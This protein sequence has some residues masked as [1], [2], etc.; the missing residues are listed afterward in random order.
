[1]RLG[2]RALLAAAPFW[3]GLARAREAGE[4]GARVVSLDL[5]LTECLLTLGERPLALAN[6]PLYRRLVA[7]PP[8]PQGVPDLGPQAEPHLEYLQALQP[9]LILAPSWQ[10]PALGRLERIAPVAWL[11]AFAADGR[12]LA[13][14]AT[15]LARIGDLVGRPQQAAA[16][17][18][19]AMDALDAAAAPL[20]PWAG[21]PVL[22]LRFMED[23]RHM[24]VFGSNGMV[25]AVLARLGLRN[26][27]TGRSNTAGVTSAGIEALARLP[28]A[29][30]I[31]FDRGAETARALARLEDSPFWRAL[32]AVRQGRLL[33]MPV[34]YPSGG[35]FSA[36]R[37]AAQLAALLPVLPRHG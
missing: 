5:L 26:A 20:A 8:V 13:H 15:L 1:M 14:A 23:G 6:I 34:I 19:R 25:G 30:L 7:Q 37:F 17:T 21:Q 2:R 33:S 3:P 12:P 27:W 31:H 28:E 16:A 10:A 29:A 18:A 36:A 24:A 11:P 4:A 9:G 22:A 32:P 35:L